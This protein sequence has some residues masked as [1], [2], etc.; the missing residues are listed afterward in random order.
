MPAWT[1]LPKSSAHFV[2]LQEGLERKF[3]EHVVA[4]DKRVD[5]DHENFTAIC[6]SLDQ[7]D[8]EHSL[9]PSRKLGK[10]TEAVSENRRQFTSIC[11]GMDTKFSDRI[12]MNEQKVGLLDDQLPPLRDPI[13][14][15]DLR[16][17]G[18]IKAEARVRA[19][20]MLEQ[21]EMLADKTVKLEKRHVE[22]T[23]IQDTRV[24]EIA[25]SVDCG[26]STCDACG[27]GSQCV[28][29]TDCA[30]GQYTSGIC[31]SCVD[32]ATDATDGVETGPDCGGSACSRRCGLGLACAKDLTAAPANATLRSASAAR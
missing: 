28:G 26:G 22:N 32:N 27:D 1:R 3:T 11:A 13:G 16:L 9:E 6:A 29:S 5:D 15:G 7:K 18:L 17:E 24:D 2:S 8:S 21:F 20:K 10:L 30:S 23:R 31:T 19:D 12:A 4:L 14:K 25:A